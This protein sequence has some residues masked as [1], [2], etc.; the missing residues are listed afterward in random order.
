MPEKAGSISGTLVSSLIEREAS[1][2]LN[3]TS[4]SVRRSSMNEGLL[5]TSTVFTAE[6]E[7]TLNSVVRISRELLGSTSIL[8]VSPLFPDSD[9]GLAHSQKP[10]TLQSESE[11]TTTS[12]MPPS[13]AA[14]TVSTE[15]LTELLS[16]WISSSLQALKTSAAAAKTYNNFFISLPIYRFRIERECTRPIIFRLPQRTSVQALGKIVH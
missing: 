6:P 1:A 14:S 12:Y 15:R 13:G 4:F 7:N 10:E 8:R 9:K 2:E 3:S 16:T 11:V 5:R